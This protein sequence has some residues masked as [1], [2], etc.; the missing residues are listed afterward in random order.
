M[1]ISMEYRIRVDSDDDGRSLASLHRWL[2]DDADVTRH[3]AIQLASRPVRPG[4]M[5]PV[6]DTIVASANDGIALGSL[7]VAYLSWRGSRT[8]APAARIERDGVV[9]SLRDCS[10]ETVGRIVEA[11]SDSADA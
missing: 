9:V 11:L 5:G 8:D 4:E 2:T 1:G 7:I 6:L 3:V 10:P